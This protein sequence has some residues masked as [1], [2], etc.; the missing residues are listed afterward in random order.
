M[1]KIKLFTFFKVLKTTTI[2]FIREGA[3]FHGAALSY[4]ILF[5]LIPL[6]YLSILCFGLI[7]GSEQW[8]AILSSLFKE[9]IGIDDISV[10]TDY[11]ATIK[12]YGR[13]FWLNV[14]MISLLLYSCSAFMV[15][16]KC[17]INEFY[18]VKKKDREQR[19]LLYDI[20]GFRF[21]SILLVALF[22]LIIFVMYFLQVFAFSFLE[23]WLTSAHGIEVF[24]YG[25]LHKVLSIGSNFLI[26]CFVFK[27][28]HD[29]KI[30]W[31]TAAQGALLTA[32]LLYISQILIK[33]YLQTYFFLGN[34]DVVGSLFILMAWIYYSS[35]VIFFGAKF[36]HILS[37]KPIETK[38]VS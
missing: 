19:N 38:V 29:G 23:S 9:N 32:V 30:D 26:F 13:S 12:N 37:V 7:I 31:K 20:I 33:Y 24:L 35:Q 1:I 3:Y 17:S 28:V 16:L 27:Y 11:F 8:I 2:E 34:G 22:A 5:A 15:S 21:V 4:Y 10:F 25:V 14:L 18:N 36:I 6:M